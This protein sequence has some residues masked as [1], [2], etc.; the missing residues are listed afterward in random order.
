MFNAG[1]SAVREAANAVKKEVLVAIHYTNVQDAG[2]YDTV[3]KMLDDNK[4]DYDVF[5]TSYYPFW[6]GTTENLTAV[7]KK[8][9]ETYNKK[10][11]V[12]EV[13]YA[14][15]LKD[16]DGHS[17]NVKEDAEGLVFHYATTVLGQANAIAY[18]MRAVCNIGAAGLVTFYCE[19]AWIPVSVYDETAANAADILAANKACL[20]YTSDAADD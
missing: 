7:L 16:G 15:T 6:H 18:T 3:A 17:N 12:A 11:M 4:V 10:V 19:P 20:L 9:A 14:Y 1:S 5:A 2:Y 13:S 8:V